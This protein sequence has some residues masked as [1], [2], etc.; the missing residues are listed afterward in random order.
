VSREKRNSDV[1]EQAKFTI[2]ESITGDIE[3]S[4]EENGILELAVVSKFFI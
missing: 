3:I 2:V 4:W 1:C